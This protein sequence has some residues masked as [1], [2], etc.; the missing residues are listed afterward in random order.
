MV[1]PKQAN[2]DI[3]SIKREGEKEKRGKGGR[4]ERVQN[5][6]LKK[7]KKKRREIICYRSDKDNGGDREG[8]ENRR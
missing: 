4:W 1:T 2:A 8:R 3:T 6:Y 7:K 5:K